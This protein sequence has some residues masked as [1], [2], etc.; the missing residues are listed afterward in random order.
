MEGGQEEEVDIIRSKILKEDDECEEGT[1]YKEEMLV[2]KCEEQSNDNNSFLA[3]HD[4]FI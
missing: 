2:G 3:V 4:Q 1:E